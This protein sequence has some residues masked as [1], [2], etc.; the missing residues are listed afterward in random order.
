MHITNCKYVIPKFKFWL[1][2]IQ[3]T[4]A[5]AESLM[6]LFPEEIRVVRIDIDADLDAH[7]IVEFKGLTFTMFPEDIEE[8]IRR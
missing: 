8:Y 4:G 3:I 5:N 7:Y 6:D 2:M 1:E